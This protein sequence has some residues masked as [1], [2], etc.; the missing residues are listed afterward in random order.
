MNII[1]I[2]C[3]RHNRG[4]NPKSFRLLQIA[5][6]QGQKRAMRYLTE[7]DGNI[8]KG[9][10]SYTSRPFAPGLYCFHCLMKHPRND[11]C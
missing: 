6:D 5:L 4:E 9:A 10:W 2:R 1:A 8:V 11:T 7:K 3:R